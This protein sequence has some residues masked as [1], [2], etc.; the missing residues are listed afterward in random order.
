M[1]VHLAVLGQS[2]ASDPVRSCV[3]ILVP[4]NLNSSIAQHLLQALLPELGEHLEGVVKTEQSIA[5]QRFIDEGL[6][7]LSVEVVPW[8][9]VGAQDFLFGLLLPDREHGRQSSDEDLRGLR[10]CPLP[11]TSLDRAEEVVAWTAFFVRKLSVEDGRSK[12]LVLCDCQ[13]SECWEARQAVLIYLGDQRD[14]TLGFPEDLAAIGSQVRQRVKQGLA[15]LGTLVVH[16]LVQLRGHPKVA[17]EERVP[18]KVL[19]NTELALL[20]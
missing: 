6:S 1:A 4:V 15:W 2:Q 20:D 19:E 11:R 10:G 3:Q 14:L 16:E 17:Q 18:V 8:A 5:L 7:P 9:A 13:T 12:E